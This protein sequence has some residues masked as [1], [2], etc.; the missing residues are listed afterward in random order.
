MS[1]IRVKHQENYVVL[2]KSALEDPNL[3]FKAKGLWAYCMSRPNNWEF[4]VKQLATVSRE[5]RDCIRAILK[6]LE[7]NGYLTV[8]QMKE[9]GRF[10]GINYEI[11]EV[12]KCLPKT[13]FPA[14]EKLETESAGPKNTTLLSNESNQ[15]ISKDI[16]MTNTNT[17]Q[18]GPRP[19]APACESFG[20]FV[21]LKTGE[22]DSLVA[23]H[24]KASIDQKI[25]AINDYLASTGKKPYKDYA[26]TIRNWIRRDNQSPQG[27]SRSNGNVAPR[28]RFAI[29][30]SARDEQ[31]NRI[32]TGKEGMF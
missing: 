32:L 24:S 21:K 5:K 1:V 18:A 9:K 29:D 20:S 4:Y 11:H 30:R 25:E 8:V 19:S 13:G 27:Q 16:L 17:P 7:K 15:S 31:G 22:Y 3:S 23:Q 6:E 12:K 14:P 2:N 10:T 28:G 26:A